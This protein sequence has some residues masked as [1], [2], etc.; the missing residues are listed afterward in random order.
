LVSILLIKEQAFFFVENEGFMQVIRHHLQS[1]LYRFGWDTR[2]RNLI[3]ARIVK[4]AMR[5]IP[6]RTEPMLLDIGCGQ[7]GIS[8]F[9]PDVSVMGTDI[10]PPVA[11][12]P[13]FTFQLGTITALPFADCSFPVVTCIDVLEHLSP[14]DRERG[15]NELVRVATRA[16]VVAYP[17]GRLAA[18]MDEEF[19]RDC[20]LHGK[21]APGWLIEHQMQPY[22]VNSTIVEQ[23]NTAVRLTGRKATISMSYCEPARVSRIVRRAAAR[24]KLLYAAV[25]LFFGALLP[26][27]RSPNDRNGYRAV[28]LIE[29]SPDG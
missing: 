17:H 12:T 27:I 19:R 28:A 3:P 23:L 2:C 16:I 8:A 7:L 11:S 22:P 14:Q 1:A 20:E 9:L 5:D 29:L 21:A 25:N 13:N 26:L 18:D 6:L 4:A 24:S 10:H 15:I